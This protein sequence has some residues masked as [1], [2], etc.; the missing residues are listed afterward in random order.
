MLW[1]LGARDSERRH[2]M[3]HTAA[4]QAADAAGI[5]SMRQVTRRFSQDDPGDVSPKLPLL[6]RILRACYRSKFRGRTA[7]MLLLARKVKALQTVPINIADWPPIYMDLRLRNS[8]F[9]FGGTPFERSPKEVDEQAVMRRFIQ[10]GD[11]VLDVGANRGL[12]TMLLAQLVGPQGRVFAFEPNPELLPTLELTIKGLSNTTLFPYALSDSNTECTFFVPADDSMG[13]LA[14]WTSDEALAK[15]R[16]T[17]RLGKA[18]TMAVQ[19]R[20]IDDLVASGTIAVPDFIK[21]DVE[22]AELMVFKG[23]RKTLDQLSAPTILFEAGAGPA[24]G[25]GFQAAD[26]V[27]YLASLPRP[28]YRVLEIG[29]AGSLQPLRRADFDDRIRNVLAVP[30]NQR[31]RCPELG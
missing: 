11:V 3:A 15:Y 4:S 9:W 14:D 17:L 25:F 13:S 29:E 12:H 2:R 28:A 23:A 26:A 30:Q 10:A 6:A 20:R 21:C 27:D 7:V 18:R 24:R 16:K 1:R 19:G 5:T 8:H 22:G 31:A